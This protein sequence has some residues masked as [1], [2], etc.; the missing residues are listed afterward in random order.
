MILLVLLLLVGLLVL[1]A[2]NSAL[3]VRVERLERRLDASGAGG[4]SGCSGARAA[5]HPPR[6]P[7]PAPEPAD[8]VTFD[9]QPD[10]ILEEEAARV[11]IARR[12]VRAAGRRAAADLARRHR[13]GARGG[14]PD[15]LFDRD[16]AGDAG[17]ADDRRGPVRPR[18]ARRR[19]ICARR[20]G[21]ADDPRIA[22]A[23]VGAGLAVLYATAYGSHVLYGLI[24]TGAAV[25]GDGRG[26]RRALWS[27]RSATARRPR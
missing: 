24:G 8:V 4:D 3:K 26:H 5:P 23:L 17:G 1:F 21:F 15:P 20:A 7:Q 2:G 22:Q 19:R 13:S 14:V 10:G 11:G 25:G 18:P 6:R 9:W 12:P 16:R 27:C